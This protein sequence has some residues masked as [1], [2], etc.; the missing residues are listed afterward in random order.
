MADRITRYYDDAMYHQR[1]YEYF[2]CSDYFNYGFWD[3]TPRTRKPP[4]KIW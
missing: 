1:L 2:G 3:E 4:V